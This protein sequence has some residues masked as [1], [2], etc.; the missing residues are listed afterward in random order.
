M[1]V[2]NGLLPHGP[3]RKAHTPH[4]SRDLPRLH[5][6][7]VT[8]PQASEAPDTGSWQ[9]MLSDG[10]APEALRRGIPRG[11]PSTGSLQHAR[12]S[13][14][15]AS[16]AAQ[17]CRRIPLDSLP[18]NTPAPARNSDAA[19]ESGGLC[20]AHEQARRRL[21]LAPHR[22]TRAPTAWQR[23]EGL[24]GTGADPCP[25]IDFRSKGGRRRRP[26]R[27]EGTRRGTRAPVACSPRTRISG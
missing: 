12:T 24:R 9:R 10:N 25:G 6:L 17:V 14:R 20:S 7:I 22:A 11:H 16:P 26:P 15:G 13:S 27:P 4:L 19:R 8:R 1:P 23:H 18:T 2:S 3:D 21:T 5:A